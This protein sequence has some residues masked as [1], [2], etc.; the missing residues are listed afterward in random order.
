MDA[1]PPGA[2]SPARPVADAPR[3]TGEAVAKGWLLALVA[4]GPLVAA[5]DLPLAD[6][7]V[8]APVLADALVAA[9]RDDDALDRLRPGETWPT[10]PRGPAAS[11]ALPTRR[12]SRPP[13]T[14]CGP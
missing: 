6:L 2:L 10:T 1:W 13:S 7:V 5:R 4:R 3:P 8:D 12:R 9:L 14:C 11:P